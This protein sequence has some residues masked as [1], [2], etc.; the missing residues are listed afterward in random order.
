MT[1]ATRAQGRRSDAP[2]LRVLMLVT[3]NQRRGPEVFATTIATYLGLRHGL[4]VQVRSLAPA[5]H[6]PRI[7]AEP[8]GRSPLTPP[9]LWRTRQVMRRSDVVV[10]CGS[11][12]L[13]ASVLAGMRTATP[14]IYQNI[15]DPLYWARPGL[16]AAR[17]RS[18]LRHTAAV[19]AV[20]EQSAAALSTHLGVPPDRISV[21]HNGRDC[22]SFFP[23][24]DRI[25]RVARRRLGLE[26]SVPVVTV[27]GALSA[28]KRVADAVSAVGTTHRHV[29]L[30]VAG[31]GPLRGSLEAHADAVAPGRVTFV[32]NRSDVASVY[33]ATDVILLTSASEGVPGVLIEA[34][35][36]GVPA[37]ATDV[38]YVDDVVVH[39]VSGLLVP[40][41]D[42]N[43]TARAIDEVLDERRRMGDAARRHCVET[44]D[45]D[46]ITEQWADLIRR[47]ARG[48]LER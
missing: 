1:G 38:G 2:P 44:F 22:S 18:F 40:V 17:V 5:E 20:S 29:Q 28:E 43:A 15:G 48:G 34:G 24:T 6:E 32:G 33:A 39:G 25:R 4:D 47:V 41:G 37:V 19:A 36:S 26:P 16:R 8:L 9:T 11:T 42:I 45:L 12:T 21:V 35:L 13:P 46:R 10:A 14:I 30:L 7:A 3:R 23:A 27:V 31:D